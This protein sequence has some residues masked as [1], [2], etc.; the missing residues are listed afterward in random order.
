[1][2]VDYERRIIRITLKPRE[3]VEVSFDKQWF[4]K[5]IEG[6]KVGEV[7]LID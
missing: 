3:Y 6:W 1:M 2:K 7:I 5:R 4:N